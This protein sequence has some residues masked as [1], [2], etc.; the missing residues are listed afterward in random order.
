MISRELKPT[1]RLYRWIWNG[2]RGSRKRPTCHE[3]VVVVAVI[4]LTVREVGTLLDDT[5]LSVRLLAGH[6]STRNSRLCDLVTEP[7]TALEVYA[8]RLVMRGGVGQTC[9]L[10]TLALYRDLDTAEPGETTTL[11]ELSSLECFDHE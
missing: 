3:G 2:K 4:Q 1:A 5:G 6:A 10:S 7:D 8:N 11:L 9:S